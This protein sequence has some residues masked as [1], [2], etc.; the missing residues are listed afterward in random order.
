[1]SI[2]LPSKLPKV[3]TT[4]FQVM[5]QMAKEHQ[6]LN[7]S[8]GF[9]DFDCPAPLRQLVAHY[10]NRG[11]NQYPP[12]IGIPELREQ[13]ALKVADLYR[14]KVD[15][16]QEVTIASGAT[17]VL[18]AA[19]HTVIRPGDEVIVFDPAYDS[20]DPAIAL[21]GGKTIHLSLTAPD[22]RVDWQNVAETLTEKTRLIL[23]N[24]PHNPTGT[25]W[26]KEDME[27]LARLVENT[28]SFRSALLKTKSNKSVFFHSKLN[29]CNQSS[30]DSSS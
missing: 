22:Y 13:I 15:M 3:G 12:M 24:T 7:L 16:E 19:I 4:I 26:R 29:E 10:V 8:Q 17:E 6:A 2:T 28:E 1:M 21:A 30:F 14:R 20:Y 9:P 11:K 27:T 25:V 5:S 23:I 18:F